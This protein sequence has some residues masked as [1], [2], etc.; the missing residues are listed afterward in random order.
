MLASLYVGV[1]RLVPFATVRL[2]SGRLKIGRRLG[3]VGRQ[4][5]GLGEGL[6]RSVDLP[7]LQQKRAQAIVCF[8][9]GRVDL[10]GGNEMG[11][12]IVDAILLGQ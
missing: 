4:P 1:R 9:I 12:G 3:V 11:G 8:G 2:R 7:A 6:D 5:Q 10:Q